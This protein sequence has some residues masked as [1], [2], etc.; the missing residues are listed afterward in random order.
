MPWKTALLTGPCI[1]PFPFCTMHWGIPC[2]WFS[3]WCTR[4]PT[5]TPH[6]ANKT[7]S[8]GCFSLDTRNPVYHDLSLLCKNETMKRRKKLRGARTLLSFHPWEMIVAHVV[9]LGSRIKDRMGKRTLN[10]ANAGLPFLCSWALS[11]GGTVHHSFV[12]SNSSL[13]CLSIPWVRCFAGKYC[14]L[15]EGTCCPSLPTY[16]WPHTQ[17][18]WR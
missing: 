10:L 6:V 7:A 16:S 18:G 1:F 3:W 9:Q 5:C 4:S 11:L 12:P 2:G 8:I 14:A 13:L 17:E 15:R